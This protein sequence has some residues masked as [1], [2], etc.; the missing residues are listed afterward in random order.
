MTRIEAVKV[1]PLYPS[2][3][4]QVNLLDPSWNLPYEKFED[5]RGN[6]SV[7][8]KS[9]FILSDFLLVRTVRRSLVG[10]NNYCMPENRQFSNEGS[11]FRLK[12]RDLVKIRRLVEDG[13]LEEAR[14]LL[15]L[16]PVGISDKFDNWH[17]VLAKPKVKA[18]KL[19]TG[20][21]IKTNF[22]WVQNESGKYKGKWVALKH[23]KLLGSHESR[24]ELHQIIKQTDNLNGA[25]FFKVAEE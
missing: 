3:N 16:I 14:H 18:E 10:N 5:T 8:T 15:S 9:E 17:R 19:A 7:S 1:N 2:W 21:N 22:S 20:Q 12:K 4:S 6:I 13:S 23:G 24:T 25:M 11:L